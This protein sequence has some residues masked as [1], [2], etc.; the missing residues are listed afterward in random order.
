M[1]ASKLSVACAVVAG[2]MLVAGCSDKP[3]IYKQGQYQGKP[4]NQPWDNALFKGNQVEWEKAIKARNQNQ[5]EYARRRERELGDGLMIRLF[6]CERLLPL[7][8]MLVALVATPVSYAVDADGAKEQAQRQQTQ[9]GNN[10]PLWRDVREGVNPY[11][12]T[13]V[14][15]VETNV[16]VQPSGQ[17]WRQ[18][19]PP[20]AVA[21]GALIATALLAV[22]AF[23]W[24]RG[25]IGVHDPATGRLIKRFSDAERFTHWTVAISVCVLGITGLIISFGKY[26]LLPVVGY[27]LFSWIA[28]FS[29]NLHNF[30]APVFFLR[31]AG[32]D[33]AV[34]ARQFS[35]ARRS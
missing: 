21:G 4:D 11:Q 12:T 1:T 3:V 16:L 25:P 26:M 33:R 32:D 7:L 22:F 15:G 24:W 27:T 8:A 29:K 23:Y 18:L 28:I 9:P 2:A 20:M 6:A 17:S 5:D 31:V 13:Q 10:A 34:R 35:R 30:V 19:R 14:R